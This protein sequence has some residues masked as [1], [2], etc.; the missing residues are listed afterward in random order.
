MIT[1]YSC[2]N[3]LRKGYEIAFLFIKMRRWKVYY[4]IM[5]FIKNIDMECVGYCEE[6]EEAV[7]LWAENMGYT[8]QRYFF[9]KNIYQKNINSD[10]FTPTG[11]FDTNEK[12]KHQMFV[13]QK[14][15]S[16]KVN[17]CKL[18]SY[19]GLDLQRQRLLADCKTKVSNVCLNS[20]S[21][22]TSVEIEKKIMFHEI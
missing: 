21:K 15:L 8:S 14:V 18:V 16:F 10:I 22:A 13:R 7:Q 4:E 5:F 2:T 9:P 19:S 1:L 12:S 20:N 17:I 11:N 6:G 3:L